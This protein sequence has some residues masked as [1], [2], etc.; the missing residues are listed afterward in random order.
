[1]WR[2]GLNRWRLAIWVSAGALAIGQAL[3]LNADYFEPTFK[4][5][6]DPAVIISIVAVFFIVMLLVGLKRMGAIGRTRWMLFGAVTYPLYLLHGNI[7]VMLF[8]RFRGALSST[9]LILAVSLV[10]LASAYAVQRGVEKPIA[11]QL[12]RVLNKAATRLRV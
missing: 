5:N 6:A 11:R 9:E 1:M 3:R 8:N 2:D 7:G 4:S 12:K 10:M